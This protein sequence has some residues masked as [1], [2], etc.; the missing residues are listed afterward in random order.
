[1]VRGNG[2]KEEKLS[3]S[4]SVR[5]SDTAMAEALRRA[6]Y[7]LPDDRVLSDDLKTSSHSQLLRRQLQDPGKSTPSSIIVTRRSGATPAIG[8]LPRKVRAP[9]QTAVPGYRQTLT[10]LVKPAG[11]PELDLHGCNQIQAYE[12]LEAFI[13]ARHLE[14]HRKVL[15]ITGK[16]SGTL[17]RLV[18]FWLETGP[19]KELVDSV[20]H[21][22]PCDGGDGALYVYLRE[23]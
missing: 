16:G 19:F 5:I 21:A 13:R 20:R 4:Y 18:P 14:G 7:D 11:P 17:K 9:L 23:G 1:M 8:R 22:D 3:R 15:V 6:G 10:I 12:R 2:T